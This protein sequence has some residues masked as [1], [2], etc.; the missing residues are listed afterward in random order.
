MLDVVWSY[1]PDDR[2]KQ[3]TT[4]SL[5][6]DLAKMKVSEGLATWPKKDL[7][8]LLDQ[9]GVIPTGPTELTISAPE[10]LISPPKAGLT[11]VPTQSTPPTS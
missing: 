11:K 2:S 5:P 4:E 7:G 8:A 1:R 10:R 9:G 6:D 3:G